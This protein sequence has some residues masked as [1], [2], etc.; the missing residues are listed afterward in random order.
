[1]KKVLLF[2]FLM[3]MPLTVLATTFDLKD[4]DMKITINEDEW[5]VFTPDNIKDNPELSE[6]GITYD[7]MVDTFEE[8]EAYL[9]AILFFRDSEDYIEIFVN[10]KEVQD[11]KNLTNYS[12][13]DWNDLG[14]ALAETQNTNH[15]EVYQTDYPFIKLVYQDQGFYLEKYYTIVNG[16]GYTITA[17]KPYDFTSDDELRVQEIIDSIEFDIDEDLKEPS[18]INWSNVFRY[19]IIGACGGAVIVTIFTVM[20]KNK[21]N[22]ED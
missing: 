3:M 6:L 13:D 20:R 10:K 7:Y 8:N 16:Y 19:A 11:V 21:K 22:N 14:E 12:L 9:D 5:Y 15:Y 4:T 2:I 18:R 17:Q 1:M